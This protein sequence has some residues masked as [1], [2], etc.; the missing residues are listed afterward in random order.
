MSIT[1]TEL[2]NFHEFAT[3]LLAGAERELSLEQIVDQWQSE[4]ERA[5]TI[6]SIRRGIA[7]AT[8]GRT[9]DLA[10]VDSKIRNE[11]GFP[12]RGQ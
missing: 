11:L 4:R 12:K 10:K 5:E 6:D 2:N 8:A 7:D 9:R 3:H 1:Q